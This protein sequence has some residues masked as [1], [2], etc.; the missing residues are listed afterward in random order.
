MYLYTAISTDNKIMNE[1]LGQAVFTIKIDDSQAT[2]DLQSWQQNLSST[3][4]K[5]GQ[6]TKSLS[7]GFSDLTSSIAS[8]ATAH[9]AL[10]GTASAIG[11]LTDSYNEYQAAMNGVKAVASATGN[12]VSAS[13]QAVKDVT[14][15]GLISQADAAASIKNLQ[16]YGYSVEEATEMINI[17]ADAAVYNRQANYS[18]SEAVR[19]T[20]EGIRMENSVLSDASGITTNIA[21][22]YE[23]YAAQLGKTSN[24]LTQAEK[25]QAVY[26]G[27][28]REGGVFAGN[29]ESYTNTLAGAQQQLDTALTEVNQT[30]GAV[31]AQFAPIIKGLANWITEN[32]ELVA[33]VAIFAGILV[34]GGGLIAALNLAKKAIAGVRTALAILGITSKVAQGGIIGLAAAAAALAAGMLVAKGVNTMAD[35][36]EDVSGATDQAT[37][38]TQNF[39]GA[40]AQATQ[41]V[42]KLRQQLANLERDY[43]QDLKQIAVNHEENLATLT[44]QIEEANVDYKRAIDERMAEF[45]V[46][47][48][49]QER[50]HQETV[51]E[52]MTQLEFLQ[53]YNNDYNKQKL[54]Q[55]QTAL[56]LEEQL[57]KKETEK[58][59]A[60]I[61]LQ[62]AAD[63]KKLDEKLASLQ[64]E[65]DD[66]KAFMDKHREELNK[67]RGEILDDEID[68][69]NRRYLEQQRSYADQIDA[70]SIAGDSIGTSLGESV[71]KTLEEQLGNMNLT[72]Y[73]TDFGKQIM[74][75]MGQGLQEAWS[76][77]WSWLKEGGIVKNIFDAINPTKTKMPSNGGW[78]SGGYTGRGGVN[79]VAGVVHRG[80]YVVP[81]NQVDQNTGL[82]KTSTTQNITINL[83]GVLAT[84][85]QAK[86]ELAAELQRALA[87]TNQARL[88]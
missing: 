10:S 22:M 18:V 57:Y 85:Q 23:N 56:T 61:E 54:L 52:L 28:L 29:A 65:L 84:S 19:T 33:G 36:M 64:K 47:M 87:Q 34:A 51:N 20:T 7:D 82:P 30:M 13:L 25:A 59:K 79:E 67:V 41:K 74:S 86:R 78:A 3:M 2:Q 88:S 16:L 12:D 48:A 69:L 71:E 35:A 11:E 72:A 77:V 31:F 62:N 27:F 46:T 1:N 5:G 83:S 37:A 58:Q 4:D 75:G 14:A 60:E 43:R 44:E 53:R 50:S 81:A 63:K 6:S 40:T 8:L 32:K 45:N 38:S 68:S 70:A 39:S 24:N 26:N 21:K 42:A 76:G 9:V 80:E 15:G 73:G 66:E 55:V 17:M 49:K